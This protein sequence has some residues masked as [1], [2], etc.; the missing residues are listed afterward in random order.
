MDGE[1]FNASAQIRDGVERAAADRAL[2][3]QA[4]PALHLLVAAGRMPNTREL[5]LDAVGIEPDARGAIPIDDHLRTRVPHVYAAGDCTDQPQL[6]YVAAAAGT[7]AAINMLGGDATLD[8]SAMLAVVFTEPQVATVGLREAEAHLRNIE[9]DS[10]TLALDHVPRA[11]ANFDT[12]GFMK[13]VAEAG[14]GRLLGVQAVAAEAGELI[15]AA[16]LAIHNRMTVQELVGQLFPYL[17]M[18][19]R[20]EAGRA[21][22][23]QGRLAALLLCGVKSGDAGPGSGLAGGVGRAC[24]AVC[25]E[26]HQRTI[27]TA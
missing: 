26:P 10:R 20:T 14:S 27:G 25:R 6:V 11:L 22:V 19:V 3:N 9:T 13:L 2:G 24:A 12:R 21:D 5:D 15:Q 8:Q 23:W 4:E 17:T 1:L 16:A 18:V 7:R